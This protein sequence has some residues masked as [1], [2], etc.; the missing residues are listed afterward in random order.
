MEKQ[1]N[2]VAEVEK[3]YGKGPA[4][5]EVSVA[6]AIKA[7]KKKQIGKT[8]RETA[9][10]KRWIRVQGLSVKEQKQI[11]GLARTNA[12]IVARN[13]TPEKMEQIRTFWDAELAS[14]ATL[15]STGELV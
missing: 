11:I 8:Q 5:M 1:G 12:L 3:M 13:R 10:N 7:R 2:P 14:C 9:Q 15:W 4:T 6:T